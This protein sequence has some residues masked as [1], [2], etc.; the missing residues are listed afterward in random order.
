MKCLSQTFETVLEN[1]A[2]DDWLLDQLANRPD[3]LLRFWQPSELAVIIG[4]GK[5]VSDEVDV[6]ACRRD[7]VLIFRRTSGGGTVL[8]SPGCLC[9]SLVLSDTHPL[10]SESVPATTR[11]ILTV[12]ASALSS[13]DDT[14]VSIAADQDLT[15]GD[16]KIGGCA[17]R[18]TRSGTL[19]H[20]TIL[21]DAD[22]S[23]IA[24]YLKQ[25]S[26]QPDYRQERAHEEFLS[27]APWNFATTAEAI[28]AACGATTTVEK[29]PPEQLNSH[30]EKLSDPSWIHS[31]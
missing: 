24:R 11:N 28:R 25:P 2:A 21:I 10:V 19:F 16:R 18:R 4:R 14:A 6:E 7:G 23:S 3:P 9:Y 1:L 22:L 8:L 5:R 13:I 15:I 29:F 27:N 30:T 20:G 31:R 17:Q 26:R 12:L